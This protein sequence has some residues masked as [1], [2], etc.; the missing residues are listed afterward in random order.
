MEQQYGMF[1]LLLAIFERYIGLSPKIVATSCKTLTRLCHKLEKLGG[2]PAKQ[3]L[4]EALGPDI[5]STVSNLTET[6][7][8]KHSNTLKV[9]EAATSLE[10]CLRAEAQQEELEYD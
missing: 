4:E 3:V 2:L 9:F 8:T 10:H 1:S 7:A 6:A 5:V